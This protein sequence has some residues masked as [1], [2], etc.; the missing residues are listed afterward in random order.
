[1]LIADK[2]KCIGNGRTS[3]S[4]DSKELCFAEHFDSLARN[5]RR[6]DRSASSTTN[7]VSPAKT[8]LTFAN[9]RGRD[10]EDASVSTPD[11][12]G[13]VDV[14]DGC[15]AALLRASLPLRIG[16]DH[17]FGHEVIACTRSD[18]Q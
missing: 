1:M 17:F 6:C 7:N 4:A 12:R 18:T 8:M 15:G 14:I 2:N 13:A 16:A 10:D 11:G 5:L 3:P 9:V